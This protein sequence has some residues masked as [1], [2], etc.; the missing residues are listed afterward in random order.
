M[1]VSQ[2]NMTSTKTSSTETLL[3]ETSSIETSSL[4]MSDSEQIHQCWLELLERAMS[5]LMAE[6]DPNRAFELALQL[7]YYEKEGNK[8]ELSDLNSP[9]YEF[10]VRYILQSKPATMTPEQLN[11]AYQRLLPLIE[12]YDKLPFDFESEVDPDSA[13]GTKGRYSRLSRV[14]NEAAEDYAQQVQRD[15]IEEFGLS[16]HEIEISTYSDNIIATLYS[17]YVPQKSFD[18]YL[19]WLE[20]RYSNLRIVYD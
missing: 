10:A 12:R 1:T 14:D 6:G 7:A 3:F 17:A 15:I 9:G 16:K 19:P 11:L 20:T 2:T 4:E 5:A 18:I 13:E 8:F